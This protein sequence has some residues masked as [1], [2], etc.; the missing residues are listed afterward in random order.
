MKQTIRQNVFETNSSS[1]HTVCMT[2]TT[3]LPDLKDFHI[4][5]HLT[6]AK[7]DEFSWQGSDWVLATPEDK[8]AYLFLYAIQGLQ[9]KNLRTRRG[10]TELDTTE[11]YDA[12]TA[13]SNAEKQLARFHQLFPNCKFL[14]EFNNEGY[15]AAAINHQSSDSATMEMI[16]R[17]EELIRWFMSDACEVHL[18]CDGDS[19]WEMLFSGAPGE[20]LSDQLYF[21]GDIGGYIGGPIDIEEYDDD[22]YG[23]NTHYIMCHEADVDAW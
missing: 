6:E 15:V 18:F 13:N 4:E 8:L 22:D 2:H 11:Y 7:Y 1:N 19:N 23:D 9:N 21:F 10:L 20:R 5:L 12:V 14:V 3:K 17:E 16:L